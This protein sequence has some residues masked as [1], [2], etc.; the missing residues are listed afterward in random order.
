MALALGDEAPN[1][2]DWLRFN[3]L[4]AVAAS[5]RD[6]YRRHMPLPYGRRRMRRALLGRVSAPPR[7][8]WT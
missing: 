4:L 2:L 3:L 8:L 1:H 5:K 7:V 6:P